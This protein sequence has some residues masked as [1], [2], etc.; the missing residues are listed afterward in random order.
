[1]PIQP[2]S[3][4]IVLDSVRTIAD[5]NIEIFPEIKFSNFKKEESSLNLEVRANRFLIVVFLDTDGANQFPTIKGYCNTGVGSFNVSIKG[6][7]YYFMQ[8]G[9]SKTK[10]TF[11]IELKDIN[12]RYVFTPFVHIEMGHGKFGFSA[13]PNYLTFNGITF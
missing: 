8:S 12:G 7:S 5:S 1:M 3:S 11:G 2:S 6:K 13:N 4:K 9:A 10:D